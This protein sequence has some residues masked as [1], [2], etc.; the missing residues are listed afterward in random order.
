MNYKLLWNY[1]CRNHVH[2][3]THGNRWSNQ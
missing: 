3:K 1:S 2:Y